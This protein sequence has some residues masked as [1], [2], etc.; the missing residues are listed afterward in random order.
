[1]LDSPRCPFLWL[2]SLRC[3]FRW[4]CSSTYLQYTSSSTT[5]RSTHFISSLFFFH[6]LTSKSQEFSCFHQTPRAGM[7]DS[8]WGMDL[9]NSS[10]YSV[11]LTNWAI[12]SAMVFMIIKDKRIEAPHPSGSR[13]S[14]ARCELLSSLAWSSSWACL[15]PSAAVVSVRWAL[16]LSAH[17]APN[18]ASLTF[19]FDFD[20]ASA[21]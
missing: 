4:L 10:L 7:T 20:S 2:C 21:I 19:T 6:S 18:P 13:L 17:S 3:P 14:N 15:G 8:A 12:S 11:H 5:P 1:M 16:M 9:S